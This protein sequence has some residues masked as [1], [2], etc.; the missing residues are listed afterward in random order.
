MKLEKR[1]RLALERML[2]D[3]FDD[4]FLPAELTERLRIFSASVGASPDILSVPV[5]PFPNT[6]LGQCFN[7]CIH[8]GSVV[9]GEI[10]HG[11]AWHQIQ[12]LF[13]VAEFHAIWR[14]P[15]H[16]LIDVTPSSRPRSTTTFSIDPIRVAADIVPGSI[17]KG[18][19]PN[20]R[21]ALKDVEEVR[22]WICAE[23]ANAS[24]NRRRIENGEMIP[25]TEV[26]LTLE[27]NVNARARIV[28][29]LRRIQ[30][31]HGR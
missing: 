13:V 18:S 24:M 28:A 3:G 21:F 14:T 8:I 19:Q 23:D 17:F 26:A 2:S 29:R 11:W 16:H 12:N 31:H 4:L 22:E 6:L 20:R 7:N 1:I 25:P 5:E 30:P 15:D 27:R 10:V 9:G